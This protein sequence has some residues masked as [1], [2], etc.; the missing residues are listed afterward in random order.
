LR[1]NRTDR[2]HGPILQRLEGGHSAPRAAR[3][4][5]ALSL[6]VAS[7]PTMSAWC[8]K[9]AAEDACEPPRKCERDEL[10][11][12]PIDC[13]KKPTRPVCYR[14]GGGRQSDPSANVCG[15]GLRPSKVVFKSVRGP[16]SLAAKQTSA[17]HSK[18][19]L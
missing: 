1:E 7:S 2:E 16:L 17:G 6:F 19:F 8:A 3:R 10:P 13:P 12:L 4:A 15:S 18:P 9:P 5:V 11:K 14:A